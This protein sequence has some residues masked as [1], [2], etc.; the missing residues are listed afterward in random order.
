LLK[1]SIPSFWAVLPFLIL[2]LFLLP[3]LI[4]LFSLFSG[5]SEN[6]A[7][8]YN[9]VLVDYISNTLYLIIGVSL[10]SLLIG[11]ISAWIVTN[12]DFFGKRFL[13]WA[14][15]LPLATPPYILAYTF[16]GF[17]DAYGTA[18]NIIREIFSLDQSFILFPNIRN[19]Y[20]AIVV[21]SFTL[22]PYIYLVSRAA[23][24]NQSRS[25][26]EAG[27]MLGLNQYEIFYK[28]SLPIIRPAVI[29]GLML[30]IM[31][32]ISDFGAVDHFAIQ[33]FTTGVFRTWHGMYDLTTAMQLASIL[34]IF[35]ATFVWIEKTSRK[36]A[37]YTS[38]SSTFKP[39][40]KIKLI[41]MKAVIAFLICFIPILIGFILPI[42]ELTKWAINYNLTF[43]DEKFLQAAMNTILLAVAAGILCASIALIINFSIRFNKNRFSNFL[44]SF[45]SLG[46]A[47]P[48]LILAVGIVQLFAL[49]DKNIFINTDIIL[50][51][52]L[53]GLI[54]A[55]VIK[56]Y[57]LANSTFESG[58]QRI[59]FHLDDSARTLNSS[60]WNL[61][62]RVHFPL[63]KTSFLTSI[64][65][66]TSE[67]VKE[68]PATLILRPFN[69]DTLAV[70]TYI[71]AAEE[72][73]FQA[74]APAIAIMLVGLI[75]I[76]L[77]TKMISSSR[78]MDK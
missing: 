51:G 38:G 78:P 36:K 40:K 46:Y 70:S 14:L 72:R 67:V 52:S 50:T 28:L 27:R 77:L 64:L 57:A 39:A 1:P 20:G 59:S 74:A 5:Y 63:L 61:L 18:N 43:F 58:F 44:S 10:T 29:G 26:L 6:W 75:P 3:V 42:T 69:F 53:I 25:I 31:E 54:F 11:T 16:T 48:G 15:I 8:L 33:T 47:V 66:V 21:F 68:L 12:Y 76:I 17:F 41:K 22:Y 30:V 19:I 2:F 24:L 62:S 4:V 55:Y 56:S 65:L 9:Y 34:L 35:V 23:F 32:T 73:M 37:L 49:I 71:Y 60:G 13:E 45:L 7:H